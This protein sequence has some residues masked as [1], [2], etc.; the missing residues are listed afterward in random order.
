MAENKKKGGCLC[1]SVSFEITPNE[2]EVHICH[3]GLCRKW[4]G[5]PGFA[6][7]CKSDWVINGEENMTWYKS[8]E[9]AER[10]FCSKCG[11]HLLFRTN[12]GSYHGVS[13]GV[14]DNQ[15]GF[16]IGMHIFVDKKPPYFDFT[17]DSP[18]LTEKEF[19]EMVGAA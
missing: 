19:L 14:L 18:R 3:C 2:E 4:H 7:Q 13:A 12:D 16:K 5:G 11:S 1:G 10:G 8:S 17:D 9:W 6:V 15:D